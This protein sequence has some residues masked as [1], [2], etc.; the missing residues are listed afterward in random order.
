MGMFVRNWIIISII[1]AVLTVFTGCDTMDSLL[2]SAGTYKIN[3]QVGRVSLDE[4]SFIAFGDEISPFFEESVSKDPDITSLI[5]QLKNTEENILDWKVVYSLKKETELYS[6]SSTR[7][8]QVEDLDEKL[9]FFKVPENIPMGLYS[10]VFQIMSG[11]DII[12]RTERDFFYLGKIAFSYDGINIHLPGVTENPQIV[13]KGQVV[14]L[15]AKLN[16]DKSMDPYIVW[17]NGKN[18]IAEGKHSEGMGCLLWETPDKSNFY[19]VR[20]EVFPV[21]NSVITAGYKKEVS[22]L[23]SSANIDINLISENVPELLKWYVFEGNL[24]DSKTPDPEESRA[25]IPL[26]NIKPKW[27]SSNGTYGLATGTNEAFALPSVTIPSGENIWQLLFRFKP[28]NEG[29]IMSVNF[30]NVDIDIEMTDNNFLLSLTSPAGHISRIYNLYTGEESFLTMGVSIT[31]ASGWVSAKL[32]VFGEKVELDELALPPLTIEAN[33]GNNFQILLGNELAAE[34]GET[35]ESGEDE[36]G[37]PEESNELSEPVKAG[38]ALS[39]ITAIWDEFAIYTN[40]SMEIIAAE[41]KQMP[42]D[43]TSTYE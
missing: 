13:S 41:V 11:K 22:V 39:V 33:A 35:D 9:P 24:N 10:M 28:V 2:S 26:T 43:L 32:N 23:I 17:Y 1:L 38:S 15:E 4:C 36:S 42:I 7:S 20:A 25:I 19:H 12:Q 5:V 21:K 30:N 27:M 37:E 14:L 18:I 29:L 16:F 40:P 34:S 8:V 31:T 3:A 6:G